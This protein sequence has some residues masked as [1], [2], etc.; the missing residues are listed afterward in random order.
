MVD[1][2]IVS[3]SNIQHD[4]SYVIPATIALNGLTMTPV[5]TGAVKATQMKYE[6]LH[7]GSVAQ[8]LP[9]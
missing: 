1:Q 5:V 7:H 2:A 8:W 4:D 9:L 3:Q 6:L